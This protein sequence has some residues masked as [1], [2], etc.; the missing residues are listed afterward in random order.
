VPPRIWI[1]ELT[2]DLKLQKIYWAEV[3]SELVDI[4]FAIKG[5]NGTLNFHILQAH[6]SAEMNV[7]VPKTGG[8]D[9]VKADLGMKSTA[10]ES[11]RRTRRQL[12]GRTTGCSG[13]RGRS[14]TSRASATSAPPTSPRPS[15]T[16]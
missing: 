4:G 7:Y 12:P 10:D 2:E 1:Y 13:W 5:K 8:E 14:P 15:S 3:G 16:G 9:V 6:P 11:S